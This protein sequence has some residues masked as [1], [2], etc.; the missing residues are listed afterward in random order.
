MNQAQGRAELYA[1]VAGRVIAG[2]REA[3][4]WQQQ[5]LAEK[6]GMSQTMIARIEKGSREMGPY[7]LNQ[8]AAAFERKPE[9]ILALIDQGVART[10]SAAKAAFGSK[11]L[12]WWQ[13]ALGI[14]G[15][16]GVIGLITFA[17]AA[18]LNDDKEKRKS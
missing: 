16:V 3:R 17:V 9:E 18:V 5:E 11:G 6:T 14:A 8:L 2:L 1:L 13:V 10:E 12:S 7:Q 4:G 15:L